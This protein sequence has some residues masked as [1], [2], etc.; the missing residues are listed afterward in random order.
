MAPGLE[1][2]ALRQ[3]LFATPVRLFT[4]GN[5][6][7]V[8][9]ER[10][11]FNRAIKNLVL[12]GL[13]PNDVPAVQAAFERL[14]PRATCTALGLANNLPLLMGTAEGMGWHLQAVDASA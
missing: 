13:Q 5:H 10:G 11:K 1:G 6:R 9:L 4:T 14:W 8:E 12:A 3:A 2:Q 7:H